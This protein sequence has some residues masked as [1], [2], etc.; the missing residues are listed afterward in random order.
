[1]A[2]GAEVAA[3]EG[4][5]EVA[6]AA[7]LITVSL[8]AQDSALTLTMQAVSMKGQATHAGGS[9]DGCDSSPT[10]SPVARRAGRLLWES[11]ELGHRRR[12]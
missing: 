3:L 5:A 9:P 8:L 7:S 6:S 2:E 11:W 1:M 4:C 12:R 10:E